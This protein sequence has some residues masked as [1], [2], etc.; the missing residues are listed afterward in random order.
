M[1]NTDAGIFLC[2]NNFSFDELFKEGIHF[3]SQ[4]DNRP[5]HKSNSSKRLSGLWKQ[6]LT[7]MREKQIPLIVHNGLLDLMYIYDS[8]IL[9]LP[10]K[11][12]RFV[13]DLAKAFSG[14]IYDTKHISEKVAKEDVTFLS[15][16]FGKYG[17][18]AQERFETSTEKTPYFYIESNQPIADTRKRKSGDDDGEDVESASQKITKKQK[19]GVV[20]CEDYAVSCTCCLFI[21]EYRLIKWCMYLLRIKVIVEVIHASICRMILT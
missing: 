3:R 21:L 15:Y 5:H 20:Y 11:L 13:M 16:L 9:A 17:R 14:G 19:A 4:S 12:E 10:E 8:F 1:I 2:K 6:M 18:L 7:I